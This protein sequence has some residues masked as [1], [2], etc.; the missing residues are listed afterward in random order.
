MVA[1]YWVLYCLYLKKKDKYNYDDD[2]LNLFGI[3]ENG[4]FTEARV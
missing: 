1:V 3:V 4:R 2:K